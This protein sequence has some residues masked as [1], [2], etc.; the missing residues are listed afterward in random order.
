MEAALKG[1]RGME[2]VG[3]EAEDLS[4][5]YAKPVGLFKISVILDLFSCFCV[6]ANIPGITQQFH[7]ELV[8]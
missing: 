5:C 3:R 7:L 4:A 1:D 8:R 6:P 2:D